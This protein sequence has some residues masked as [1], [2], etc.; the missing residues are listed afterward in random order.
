MVF[1]FGNCVLDQ[2]ARQLFRAGKE[3][4]LSPK[5]FELLLLLV[6]AAPKAISKSALQER[7]WPNTFVAEANLPNLVGEIRTAL[8]DAA[9]DPQ[10]IR[11]VA[12]FG[13]ACAPEVH[14]GD[15]RS[16]AA[17]CTLVTGKREWPLSEGENVL[18]RIG[19]A[20]DCFASPT[21]SR[22]HARIL[23]KD[24]RAVLEDLAS[25]NGTFVNGRRVS[26]PMPL[27]D[28]D[29]VRLGSVTVLFRRADG[30]EATETQPG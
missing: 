18:G 28:G 21:V 24:G 22:K 11:T 23:I 16:A 2:D 13:Y 9:R 26:A 29:E 12:R 3:L 8:G 7:L 27:S 30:G 19:G 4:R 20:A 25:K 14:R 15:R 17:T 5:A 6:D 1:R 10:Y